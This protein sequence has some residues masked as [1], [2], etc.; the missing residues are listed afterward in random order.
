[1][2]E[3]ILTYRAKLVAKACLHN[4]EPLILR[5]VYISLTQHL[6]CVE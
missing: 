4:I 6:C 5:H 1:M 3:K 2:E